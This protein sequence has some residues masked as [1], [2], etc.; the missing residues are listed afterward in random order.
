[1][2]PAIKPALAIFL[3]AFV[4]RVP[5]VFL[6]PAWQAPDEYSHFWVA[7]EIAKSSEYPV[8]SFSF[9]EYEAHHPPMYYIVAGSILRLVDSNVQY[10]SAPDTLPAGLVILRLFSALLG[11]LTC[12]IIYRFTRLLFD[13]ERLIPLWAAVF[14]CLLPSWVGVSS[15]VNNDTLTALVSAVCLLMLANRKWTPTIALTAGLLAGAALSTKLSALAL[16]IIAM[17]RITQLNGTDQKTRLHLGFIAVT[18]CLVGLLPLL[19]RNITIYNQL[20]V[21]NVGVPS[22]NGVT[23]SNVWRAATNLLRSFWLSFGAD[24][25]IHPETWLYVV[26]ILP[27]VLLAF[28]GS[29]R[30]W[31]QHRN[32]LI[33]IITGITVSVVAS[34]AYT[35]SYPPG[36]MTSW[37]KNLFPVLPLISAFFALGWTTVA[38]K[39][40]NGFLWIIASV[41]TMG[42]TWGLIKLIG[43]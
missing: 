36:K 35:L 2:S 39:H 4:F 20:I 15:S 40:S 32:V 1:M 7:Q 26:I 5:F 16:P 41:L 3:L 9:P 37:G 6:T 8:A 21:Y 23:V 43:A 17:V 34:L 27:L 22:G 24:Y 18:G 31:H 12:V 33:L 10:S 13:D 42:C 29:L 11:S 14:A 38:K 30:K 19:V 28:Y 25:S